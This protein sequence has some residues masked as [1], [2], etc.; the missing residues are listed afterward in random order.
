M[1]RMFGSAFARFLSR[2]PD[3]CHHLLKIVEEISEIL[4]LE[5][6]DSE[7]LPGEKHVGIGFFTELGRYIARGCA[8]GLPE[9]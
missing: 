9:Y 5:D 3:G 2:N 6:P 7:S 1:G 8:N 4:K